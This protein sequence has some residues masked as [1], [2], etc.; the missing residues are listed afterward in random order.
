[1]LR[2]LVESGQL[3]LLSNQVAGYFK[4]HWK[5]P[6]N[7]F[8]FLP[9][10]NHQGKVESKTSTFGRVWLGVSLVQS[11]SGILWSWSPEG[12]NWYLCL[13]IV[14]LPFFYLASFTKL[15]MGPFSYDFFV[16]NLLK[17]HFGYQLSLFFTWKNNCKLRID[18]ALDFTTIS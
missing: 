2:I 1:M 11:D 4:Y 12:I 9:G 16:M 18:F 14:I 6:I 13:T 15:S 3:C 8:D 7:S 10:D 17:Y 5:E